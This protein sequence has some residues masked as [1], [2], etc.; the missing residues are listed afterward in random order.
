MLRRKKCAHILPRRAFDLVLRKGTGHAPLQQLCVL[1]VDIA[2]GP[3][4]HRATLRLA[5]AATPL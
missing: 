1:S 2:H 3:M 4:P 5:V